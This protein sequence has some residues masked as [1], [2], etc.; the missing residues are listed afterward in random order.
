VSGR[1]LTR[2][3][4]RSILRVPRRWTLRAGN[5]PFAHYPFDRLLW[6]LKAGDKDLTG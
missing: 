6:D 4:P 1:P 3:V 2:P 5:T